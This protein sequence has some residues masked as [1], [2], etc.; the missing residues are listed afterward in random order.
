MLWVWQASWPAPTLEGG[1]T[2]R[3]GEQSPAP[4]LAK[5]VVSAATKVGPCVTTAEHATKVHRSATRCN[6]SE[7]VR[8]VFVKMETGCTL[9]I[10]GRSWQDRVGTITARIHVR[11]GVPADPK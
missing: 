2:I 7:P 11:Q 10:H 8:H 1:A 6:D 9:T 5:R 4:T 3:A